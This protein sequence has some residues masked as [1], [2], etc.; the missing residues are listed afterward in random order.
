MGNHWASKRH[1]AEAR[2]VADAARLRTADD[3]ARQLRVVEGMRA[4]MVVRMDERRQI[5]Q[6]W[7]NLDSGR[8]TVAAYAAAFR[9][10]H[11]HYLFYDN[12]PT[13]KL[14]FVYKPT[15]QMVAAFDE[16]P[17]HGVIDFYE[18]QIHIAKCALV[19]RRYAY[20]CW[21]LDSADCFHSSWSLTQ[22]GVDRVHVTTKRFDR[23][24]RAVRIPG[25]TVDVLGAAY[26]PGIPGLDRRILDQPMASRSLA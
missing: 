17:D 15:E 26:V 3:A 5:A 1:R 22:A 4:Y 20:C 19:K 7:T 10:R 21:M 8:E 16:D 14:D 11:A 24:L 12:T 13:D 25:A 9:A 23:R 6:Q 18:G 2:K